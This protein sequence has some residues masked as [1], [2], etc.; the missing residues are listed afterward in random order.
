MLCWRWW[1]FEEAPREDP[2]FSRPPPS[3]R[4]GIDWYA[5]CE[6][7]HR[8]L[9]LQT[10]CYELVNPDNTLTDKGETVLLCY[11]AGLLLALQGEGLGTLGAPELGRAADCPK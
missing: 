9:G 11:G 6:L 7:A 5:A 1:G 2:G 8:F 4:E 10:P 3:Q